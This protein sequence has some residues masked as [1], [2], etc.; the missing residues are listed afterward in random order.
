[1]GGQRLRW[2]LPRQYEDSLTGLMNV[3]AP[4]YKEGTSRNVTI[5]LKILLAGLAITLVACTQAQEPMRPPSP[6]KPT[7]N[8]IQMPDGGMCMDKN[9]TELL[10]E[11]IMQLEACNGSY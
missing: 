5:W 6:A 1:M 2:L 7:L 4:S 3:N 10:G 11:Y 9:N 8:I